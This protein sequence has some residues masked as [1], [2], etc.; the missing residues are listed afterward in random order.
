MLSWDQWGHGWAVLKE[1]SAVL[2]GAC[3]CVSHLL[4]ESVWLILHQLTP[5]CP[6]QVGLGGELSRAQATPLESRTWEVRDSQ[7]SMGVTLAKMPNTGE[8]E[9]EES[10]FSR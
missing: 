8:S 9:L 6:R 4:P 5:N 3:Y 7:D 1:L 10:T 2:R